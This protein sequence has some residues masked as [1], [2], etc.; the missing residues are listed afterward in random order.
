VKETILVKVQGGE[1]HTETD[2]GGVVGDVAGEREASAVRVNQLK[3][4][5]FALAH[6]DA[7]VY[8]AAGL[9]DV[10]DVGL[11][12]PGRVQKLDLDAEVGSFVLS[13]HIGVGNARRPKGNI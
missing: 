12:L 6:L 10:A 3:P 5:R 13:R 9:A 4:D 11:V 1:T 7:G 2:A 8:V